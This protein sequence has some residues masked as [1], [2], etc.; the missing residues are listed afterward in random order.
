MQAPALPDE[1]PQQRHGEGSAGWRTVGHTEVGLRP[2]GQ[3]AAL[4]AALAALAIVALLAPPRA[5]ADAAGPDLVGYVNALRAAHGIPAQI[6]ERASLSAGCAL[7]NR[8]G[9]INDVLTHV[10]GAGAPGFTAAGAAAGATSVLYR[11]A[12][13]T[14]ADNPYEHAPIHLH[15]L[16][17]PR[18]DVMG[19]SE[20]AGFGCA[21]TLAGRGRPAPAAKVTYT[22]PA[23]GTTGGRPSEV[24]AELPQTPGE[25]LGL[26]AGT[27]TGPYLYV[28]FDG[29][30]IELREPARVLKAAL[31]G[32][33]GSVA[34]LVADNATPGLKGYLPT[35]AELIPRRPLAPGTTYTA[36][37]RARVGA[38][39]FRHRWSFTTGGVAPP[40]GPDP[41]T[42]ARSAGLSQAP[43]VTA[44]RSADVIS[45]RLRCPRTC[46]VR[47]IGELRSSSGTRRLPYARAGRLMGGDIVLR[48]TLSDDARHWLGLRPSSVRLGLSVS[49]LL[50][51]SLTATLPYALTSGSSSAYLPL[52]S[53]VPSSG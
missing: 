26:P 27:E 4:L 20:N 10:E 48:F 11:G 7:H 36:I 6:A 17:A 31:H 50:V 30:G 47:G 41:S 40:A 28:L 25:L 14:A 9:A 49:G 22:Y 51:Q 23:D 53:S 44:Q 8:Y 15:Q 34:I 24:A 43:A 2:P 19:A 29:P 42:V 3:V 45:V 21:T 16:L 13:W 35:G 1:R 33:E 52:A 18:L 12:R 32:P 5:A 46:L 39:R 38:T 37:V